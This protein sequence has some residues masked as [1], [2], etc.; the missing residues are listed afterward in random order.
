MA[1]Q[2]IAV[3]GSSIVVKPALEGFIA[4]DTAWQVASS[5]DVKFQLNIP[6]IHDTPDVAGTWDQGP[7]VPP[8]P[9]ET[10]PQEVPG[11]GG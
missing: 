1:Y 10:E 11:G 8:V 3:G 7:T 2:R 5:V 6:N 4:P 9:D